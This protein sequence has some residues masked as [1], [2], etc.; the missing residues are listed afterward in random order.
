MISAASQSVADVFDR[1]QLNADG[2]DS[3]RYYIN[4][5]FIAMLDLLVYTCIYAKVEDLRAHHEWYVARIAL[6]KHFDGKDGRRSWRAELGG[7]LSDW[8][9]RFPNS[10]K[11]SQGRANGVTTTPS[12]ADEVAQVARSLPASML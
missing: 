9:R 8:L 7:C 1:K 2:S 3:S 11:G 12:L 6:Y 10:V 5:E 4:E